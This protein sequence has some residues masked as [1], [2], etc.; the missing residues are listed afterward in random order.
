MQL[1]GI[2]LALRA[3][4]AWQ[5]QIPAVLGCRERC[6]IRNKLGLT[7]SVRVQWVGGSIVRESELSPLDLFVPV[8]WIR[9]RSA[10]ANCELRMN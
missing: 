5:G 9:L 7:L 2:V 4:F 6:I 3:D 1:F 8:C 10:P